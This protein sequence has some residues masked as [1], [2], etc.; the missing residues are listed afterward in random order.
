VLREAGGA[1][2]KAA[3]LSGLHRSTL[4][5]KLARHGLVEAGKD[6]DAP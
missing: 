4:Y 5:E 3:D 6:K 2:G 1:V